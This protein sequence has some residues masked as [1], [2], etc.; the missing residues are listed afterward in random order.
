MLPKQIIFASRVEE[1][2]QGAEAAFLVTEW[3]EIKSLPLAMYVELMKQPLLFDGR[4]CYSLEEASHHE[5]DY[6]SIGRPS[7]L[8]EYSSKS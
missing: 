2:L 5:I 1:A 8:R 7:V 4:N 6:Y 3:S